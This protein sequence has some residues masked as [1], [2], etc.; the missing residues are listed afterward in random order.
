MTL[1]AL[2]VLMLFAGVAAVML[3]C[4]KVGAALIAGAVLTAVRFV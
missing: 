3:E 4:S 2:A 1:I